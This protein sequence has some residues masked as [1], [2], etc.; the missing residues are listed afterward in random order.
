MKKGE[1]RYRILPAACVTGLLLTALVFGTMYFAGPAWAQ[2]DMFKLVEDKRMELKTREDALK[3]EEERLTILRKDVD[4]KIAKYTQLL[5]QVDEA[6]KKA[7]QIQSERLL[8]MAKMYEA[9][10]PEAAAAQ[11]SAMDTEAAAQIM[12]RMKSKKSGAVVALLTPKKAVVL[13]KK[14]TSLQIKQ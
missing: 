10:S 8:N 4:E 3:K 2:E 1:Y 11:L 14:M 12:L 9:M 5:A 6:L 7:E 13:T